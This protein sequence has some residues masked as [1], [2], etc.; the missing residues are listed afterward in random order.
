MGIFDY[1]T[2]FRIPELHALTHAELRRLLHFLK[3][4]LLSLRM[5]TASIP[6]LLQVVG[7]VC[8]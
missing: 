4:M 3:V 8:T 7:L 1:S 6:V 5:F 2:S